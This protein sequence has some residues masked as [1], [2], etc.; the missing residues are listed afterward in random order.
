M[1]RR[2]EVNLHLP[3]RKKKLFFRKLPSCEQTTNIKQCL[4]HAGSQFE[5]AK[6]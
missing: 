5:N 4:H 3:H 6:T 1:K 2:N